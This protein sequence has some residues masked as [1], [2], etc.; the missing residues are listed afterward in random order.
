MIQVNKTCANCCAPLKKLSAGRWICPYCDTEFYDPDEEARE[1][2]AKA[3]V[4][5]EPVQKQPL[6]STCSSAPKKQPVYM[7]RLLDEV[8]T[9]HLAGTN[10]SM[11]LR[12]VAMVE[13]NQ[14][15]KS[16]KKR[17]GIPDKDHCHLLLDTG[18]FPPYRK[19]MALCDNGIHYCSNSGPEAGKPGH[20]TWQQFKNT[21]LTANAKTLSLSAE[22]FDTS[23]VTKVMFDILYDLQQKLKD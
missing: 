17:F 9:H 21:R 6:T 14:H 2:A 3:A 16:A 7:P 15:F 11:I 18:I 8:I 1:R 4:P 13:S 20:L 22:T 10:P 19:G 5:K 12:G 23:Y